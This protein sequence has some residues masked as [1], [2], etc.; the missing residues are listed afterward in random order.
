MEVTYPGEVAA[1]QYFAG[2]GPTR[3]GEERFGGLM[4]A[5]RLLSGTRQCQGIGGALGGAPGFLRSVPDVGALKALDS[6]GVYLAGVRENL[7]S[8]I[9]Y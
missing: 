6:L 4:S 7:V 8:P 5:G 2:V 9:L 1:D 3:K